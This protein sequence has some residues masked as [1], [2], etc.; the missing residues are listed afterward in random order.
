MRVNNSRSLDP[1]AQ[2][3]KKRNKNRKKAQKR[4]PYR[5]KDTKKLIETDSELS[6]QSDFYRGQKA[7]RNGMR[8]A[9]SQSQAWQDQP[10]KN[11]DNRYRNLKR[12]LR[13]KNEKQKN[14]NINKNKKPKKKRGKKKYHEDNN[15]KTNNKAVSKNLIRGRRNKSLNLENLDL[16]GAAEERYE[17][18]SLDYEEDQKLIERLNKIR[19]LEKKLAVKNGNMNALNRVKSMEKLE[20]L[21][22]IQNVANLRKKKKLPKIRRSYKIRQSVFDLDKKVPQDPGKLKFHLRQIFS[23]FLLR[24][25]S[26]FEYK[27]SF[28]K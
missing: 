23:N 3:A 17:S 10:T 25:V 24:E 15:L 7:W 20:S 14:Q 12:G 1:G 4:K 11:K 9:L 8:K 13:A 16:K 28:F 19:R 5:A 2:P 22:V 27:K 6:S 26:F 21:R 18:E